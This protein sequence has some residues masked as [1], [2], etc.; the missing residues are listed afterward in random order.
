MAKIVTSFNKGDAS[1]VF[2]V[3]ESKFEELIEALPEIETKALNT[4]AAILKNEIKSHMVTRMPAAGRPFTI[5]YPKSPHAKKPYIT[6]PEPIVE[7][8]R[9]SRRKG[10]KVT[11][12]ANGGTPHTAQYLAKMYEHDSKPRYQKKTKRYL[13]KLI[14]LH[15]FQDG[16]ITGETEAVEAMQRV[17]TSKVEKIIE[18]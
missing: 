18:N 5:K 11:V 14:G 2:D 17:F 13:G 1:A 8:I 10:E 15:Y 16:I 4:G 12:S 9:Q 3:L 7:G 6:D